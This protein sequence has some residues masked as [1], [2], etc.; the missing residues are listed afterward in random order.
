MLLDSLSF[1]LVN[2]EGGPAILIVM[3]CQVIFGLRRRILLM[4]PVGEHRMHQ[5]HP[6]HRTTE[7]N[8]SSTT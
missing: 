1:A 7:M 3:V 2:G 8:R 4:S 6:V 5:L